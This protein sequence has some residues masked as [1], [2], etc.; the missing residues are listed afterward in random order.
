[1][2]KDKI[3]KLE[4]KINELEKKLKFETEVKEFEYIKILI[5]YMRNK[6]D[7]LKCRQV[8]ISTAKEIGIPMT[9]TAATLLGMIEVLIE[10]NEK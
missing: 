5:M 3:A 1:M 6:Y 9:S 2:K 8:S 7:V 10:N 4:E